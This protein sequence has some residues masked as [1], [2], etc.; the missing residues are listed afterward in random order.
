[1]RIT[2]EEKNATR[3]RIIDVAVGLFRTQGFDAT[4]TR[5]IAREAGIA[6]GT[7]FNYFETKEAIVAAVAGEA[8]AKA[9]AEWSQKRESTGFEESLFSLIAVQLRQLRPIRK[10]IEPFLNTSLSLLVASNR[11]GFDPLRMQ[12]LELVSTIAQ[13]NGVGELSPVAL[14]M[15]WTLYVGVVA[16]WATD[17][18]RGQEQT[19]ALLDGSLN[20]FVTWLTAQVNDCTNER[21]GS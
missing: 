14:Q 5:E 21:E 10:F 7:L 12:H 1:M 20:M 19:L 18:S 6:A 4:S 8:L 3:E 11:T 13:R 17:K 16:F 9:N 15:Y 2:T